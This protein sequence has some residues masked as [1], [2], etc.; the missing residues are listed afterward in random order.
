VASEN[1]ALEDRNANLVAFGRLSVSN[2]ALVARYEQQ[3]ELANWNISTF[4][5]TEHE[6]YTAY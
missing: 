1:K 3:K 2:L 5:T 4:C 6:G